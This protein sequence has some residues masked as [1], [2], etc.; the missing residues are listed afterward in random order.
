MASWLRNKVNCIWFR[1]QQRAKK[2]FRIIIILILYSSFILT[3]SSSNI[4]NYFDQLKLLL[5]LNSDDSITPAVFEIDKK[6]L[7]QIDSIYKVN[8]IF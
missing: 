2:V 6:E 5:S 3:F 1:G 7:D 8:F 4:F